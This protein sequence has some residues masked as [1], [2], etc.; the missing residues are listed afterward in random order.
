MFGYRVV[1]TCDYFTRSANEATKSP[2]YRSTRLLRNSIFNG[3]AHS[4][5]S[6]PISRIK[7]NLQNLHNLLYDHRQR[8]CVSRPSRPTILN[9]LAFI[10]KQLHLRFI[11]KVIHNETA[12][13]RCIIPYCHT[14]QISLSYRSYIIIRFSLHFTS[15]YILCFIEKALFLHTSTAYDS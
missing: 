11:E 12:T 4:R 15:S 6:R 5:P 9:G 7:K 14:Q 1:S 2:S 10:S 8:R 3:N 13:K